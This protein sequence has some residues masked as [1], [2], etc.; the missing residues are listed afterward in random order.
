LC[1]F[2]DLY[3]LSDSDRASINFIRGGFP[4][5][6]PDDSEALATPIME[7]DI[8]AALSTMDSFKAPDYDGFQPIFYKNCWDIVSPSVCRFID[9][10][11]RHSKFPDGSVLRNIS[12]NLDLLGFVIFSTK[13]SPRSSL[14]GS[15]LY[16][17]NSSVQ[18][19]AAFFL[20]ELLS[21][22]SCFAR[23]CLLYEKK[24]RWPK[25]DAHEIGSREGVQ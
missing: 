16:F 11:L 1:Y 13:W 18:L 23:E 12:P 5:I 24:E 10:F 17:R 20:E 22:I 2:K 3:S 4:P 14:I 21:T 8:Y 6:S 7:K 19:R 9:L 15:N 25:M